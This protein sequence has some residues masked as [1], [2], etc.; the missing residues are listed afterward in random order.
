[1]LSRAIG[2]VFGVPMYA[3]Y[4]VHAAG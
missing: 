1:M 3:V 2:A 4:A